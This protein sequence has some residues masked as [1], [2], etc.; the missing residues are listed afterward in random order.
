MKTPADTKRNSAGSARNRVSMERRG[1]HDRRI[2]EPDRFFQKAGIRLLTDAVERID[3]AFYLAGRNDRRSGGRKS[4]E[5]L[6][7]GVLRRSARYPD[8]ASAD[9]PTPSAAWRRGSATVGHACGQ[10]IGEPGHGVPEPAE[11]GHLKRQD[12]LFRE[13]SQLRSAGQDWGCGNHAD[14]VRLR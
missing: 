14:Q 9:R 13:V 7:S 6:L 11:L 8:R 2:L 4:V 5:E 10:V 12:T 1:N 3:D